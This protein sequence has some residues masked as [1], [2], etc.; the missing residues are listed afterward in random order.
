[1]PEVR[2]REENHSAV[3][4]CGAREWNQVIGEFFVF[5]RWLLRLHAARLRL[6]L[7]SQFVST[8]S[9]NLAAL[10]AAAL[11]LNLEHGFV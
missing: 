11:H 10:K 8:V 9:C 6:P 2:Q 5:Y 3:G 4:V 7:D 1:M